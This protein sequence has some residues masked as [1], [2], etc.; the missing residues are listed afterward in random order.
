MTRT[1]V[2]ALGLLALFGAVDVAAQDR[3]A[4]ATSTFQPVVPPSTSPSRGWAQL[5]LGGSLAGD[6]F[7]MEVTSLAPGA[8]EASTNR[9]TYHTGSGFAVDI[10][11]GYQLVGRIGVAVAFEHADHGKAADIY[12]NVP[13][14]LFRNAFASATMTTTGTL[15]R[16]DSALHFSAVW[17]APAPGPVIVRAFAGPSWIRASQEVFSSIGVNQTYGLTTPTNTIVI[18]DFPTTTVNDSAWGFHLGADGTYPL[19]PNVGVGVMLRYSRATVNLPNGFRSSLG[20]V[21]AHAGGFMYGVGG[22]LF[23]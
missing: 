14:P 18:N 11:A 4:A 8:V 15:A 2:M 3:A 22:R 9:G 13:H 5:N 21:D 12:A 1:C 7:Q 16:S 23:F 10:G 6:D 19:T 20:T 17:T